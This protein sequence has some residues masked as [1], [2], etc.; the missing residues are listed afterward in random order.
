MLQPARGRAR[1][2]AL[3]TS[4][5]AYCSIPAGP[6]LLCYS[7]KVQVP[8]PCLLQSMRGR[9][10]S[11]VL[12][13]TG[14]ALLTAADD[15]GQKQ[16]EHLSLTHATAQQTSDR[17][18]CPARM[19]SWPAHLQPLQPRSA[20]LCYPGECQNPAPPGAGAGEG[21]GQR[22]HSPDPRT[23]SSTYSRWGCMRG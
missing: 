15:K 5:P 21:Q 12:I 9:A 16:E 18:S 14:P 8:L 23:N 10:S 2:L 13:T 17:T 22:S 6:A 19:P 4:R 1:S 3:M 11:P 7:G 20:L